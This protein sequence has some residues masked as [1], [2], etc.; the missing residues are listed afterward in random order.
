M[1]A[2]DKIHFTFRDGFIVAITFILTICLVCVCYCFKI[3]IVKC[4]AYCCKD[5]NLIINI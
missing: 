1:Y 3:A 4:K 5:D 2:D